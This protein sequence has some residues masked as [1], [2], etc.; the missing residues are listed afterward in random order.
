M[1]I[2]ISN[3]TNFNPIKLYIMKVNDFYGHNNNLEIQTFIMGLESL[4]RRFSSFRSFSTGFFSRARTNFGGTYN[5]LTFMEGDYKIEVNAKKSEIEFVSNKIQFLLRETRFHSGFQ[6]TLDLFS[7]NNARENRFNIYKKIA[8]K[9]HFHSSF[10]SKINELKK[11]NDNLL[12]AIVDKFT[13]GTC[14]LFINKRV[15]Q[16]ESFNLSP[17]ITLHYPSALIN[18]E[19]INNFHSV[20]SNNMSTAWSLFEHYLYLWRH[21]IYFDIGT[22]LNKNDFS[23]FEFDVKGNDNWTYSFEGD[24]KN[25]EKTRSIS[26]E[27]DEYHKISANGLFHTYIKL[28]QPDFISQICYIPNHQHNLLQKKPSEFFPEWAEWNKHMNILY[29]QNTLRDNIVVAPA[30]TAILKRNRL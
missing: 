2:S 3:M 8:K 17:D 14:S 5:P 4:F 9:Y 28:K 19:S 29:E 20:Y 30:S 21:K 10:M 26:K 22:G 7:E 16:S 11:I 6:E 27:I 18:K 23:V 15:S 24:N 1:D 13:F 25:I 12:Y